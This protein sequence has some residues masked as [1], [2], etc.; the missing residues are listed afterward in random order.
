MD[1][2]ISRLVQGSI[3]NLNFSS[4]LNE[5]RADGFFVAFSVT[6]ELIGSCG[7]VARTLS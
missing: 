1:G 6:T 2:N 5:E 7:E 3:S 4:N